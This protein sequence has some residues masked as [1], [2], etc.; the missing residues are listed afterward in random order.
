VAD[1]ARSRARVSRGFRHARPCGAAIAGAALLVPA[2]AGALAAQGVRGSIA[3]TTRYVELRPLRQDTVPFDRLET[4]A[5]GRLGYQGVPAVCDAGLCVVRRADDVQHGLQ[6]V[7]TLDLTAWG[8]GLEGLSATVLLRVRSHLH[9]AYRLPFARKPFEA[10]LAYAELTRGLYRLRLGRQRELSGLGFSGFD[11]V[12]LLVEP[13]R[14]LRARVYGGRSLARS[15]QQPLA[16]AFRTGD[17]RDFVRDRDALLLGGEVAIEAGNGSTLSA[18]YQGEVWADRAGLLAERALLEGRLTALA[19]VT[20]SGSVEY[21]VGLAR[22]GTARLDAQLPLRATGTRLEATAR[23]YVPFFEYW[24]IWGMFS[25]AAYREAELRVS[26]A[27]PG[28]VGLWA[29]GGYRRYEPHGTQ[30]FLRPLEGESLHLAAG[31]AWRIPETL[32]L[33]AGLRLDGPVGAFTVS[34]DAALDWRAGPRLDVNAYALLLEQIEEYR[35]GAGMVAGGGLGADVAV[36]DGLRVAGGFE[37]Y[38]QT[39]QDRPGRPDWTQRRGW[40]S[41]RLGI[42]R[43]PGLPRGNAP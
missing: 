17:E 42:G 40:L 28:S 24:T 6:A 4:L 23:R 22:W 35:V 37:L 43:D 8:L 33:T 31:G 27:P 7:H 14:A 1:S 34:G 18:R 12:D 3:S 38:R 26:W 2:A 15:V 39:Q 16:R 29:A 9:G 13:R 5:D 10:T 30:T 11:G 36:A 21:D 25:P 19:P 41:V 32:G 20:L